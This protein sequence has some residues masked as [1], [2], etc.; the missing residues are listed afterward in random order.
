MT[1][2]SSSQHSVNSTSTN[3]ECSADRCLTDAVVFQSPNLMHPFNSE[4]GVRM[5][6]PPIT[7]NA[8]R[9]CPPS[10]GVHVP[11]IVYG[12][13]QEQMGRPNAHSVVAVMANEHSRRNRTTLEEPRDSMGSRHLL[14]CKSKGS[15]LASLRC[16]PH[17]TRAKVLS[18]DRT[19]FID[20]GPEAFLKSLI[21]SW[22]N[23]IITDEYEPINGGS[24]A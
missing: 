7:R 13:T 9:V 6:F 21:P 22:H 10:F 2:R 12:F 1:P 17:P 15:V 8:A 23:D 18:D 3:V 20:F 19:I 4:N 16:D 11:E 5:G 24:L 14:G